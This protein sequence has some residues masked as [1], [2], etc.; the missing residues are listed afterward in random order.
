MLKS[1]I[2]RDF[3]EAVATKRGVSKAELE[4][5]SFALDGQ[6]TPAIS[7]KL[8]ITSV[9]VRKRLGEVYKKFNI[10]GSGPGKL[11]EL[12]QVLVSQYQTHQVAI[13]TSRQDWGEANNIGDFYG[14]EAELA[15]L[16][17]WVVK[18][19]CRL[20]AVLGMGGIGKTSL[21][22][23]LAER[24]QGEFENV[25]WRSLRHA[26][27]VTDLLADLIRFLSN[28]Q[29]S[30]LPPTVESISLLINYLQTSRCLLILDNAETILQSDTLTGQYRAG[31]E[32]YSELLT[33][34]GLGRVGEVPHQSCLVLTSRE[35]PQ[36]IAEY[37]GEQLLIRSLQLS[38][39]K[40][41]KEIL[42]IKGLSGSDVDT[43]KLVNRYVGNPL[44]LKI[45][46]ATIQ[47]LFD[48]NIADFLAQSTIVFGG[49]R[50]LL[51]Q[52]FNR[53]SALEEKV[54]YWLAINREE[55]VSLR[56]LQG[57]MLPPMSQRE[58]IEVLESLAKRSLIETVAGLFWLQPV[59]MEYVTARLI[60]QVCEEISG[61]HDLSVLNPESSIQ[62]LEFKTQN[63]FQS[64]ALVKAQAKDYIRNTQ[65]RC[66]LQAVT[67]RLLKNYTLGSKKGIEEN[68]K[69]ILTQLRGKSPVEIGYAGGN[70]INMLCQLQIDLTGYDFSYLTV[71]QAYLQ[72][73]DLHGVNFA[74]SNLAK[75]VFTDTFGSILSVAFSPNGQL[76]ATG[77][78]KGEVRL[79]QV[80]DSEQ[81]FTCKG[82][83]GWVKSVAF[84]PDGR[85]LASGSDDRTIKLWDTSTGQCR[86][87]LQGHGN[88]LRSVSFSPDGQ[89]L[90]SGSDDKTLRLWDASTGQALKT[91]AEYNRS[92]LSVAFSPDG[93]ILASGSSDKTLRLW[94]VNT[95]EALKPLL[96]HTRTIRSV[97]F[98][99]DGRI[100]A[101]GSSDQT[102]K[103]WDVST[104]QCLKTLSGHTS[105]VWSVAFN[106]AGQVASGS[107]DKT[108]RLWDVGTGQ[109]LKTLSGHTSR[110]WSVA[111]D[112]DDQIAS[113]SDDQ[114]VRL[115]NISTGQCIETLQGYTRSLRAVAFAPQRN[116]NSVDMRIASGGDD[117]TVRLWDGSTGQ[118]IKALQ[119]HTS[120]IWS[121]AFSPDGQT[122]ASGSDDQTVRL[123][124]VSTGQCLKILPDHTN[125]VRSVAF[126]PD[127]QTLASSSDDQT[128]KLWDVSTG[129]CLKTL[130]GHTDWVWSVA[131]RPNGETLASGSNDRT[132]RL[133]DVS[134]D[135]FQTLL[136]HTDWVRS[137]A[138]SPEGRTVA[139]SSGDRT[140]RLWDVSTGQCLKILSDMGRLRSVAFSPDGRSLAC[141][142]EDKLVT[143]WDVNTGL[144]LKTLQGHTDWVR[145]V[146]FNSQGTVLASGSKDETIKLW[147]IKTGECL[148]TLKTPRPYEGMNITG[149]T[150][151]T[152]ATVATL[153]AL[154][155]VETE[156]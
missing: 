64:H 106:S 46:S 109:C 3:L 139:S 80:T 61:S 52:Q 149:V 150:G 73:I 131:F 43:G 105:R 86:Q 145:S 4:V 41:A 7:E 156:V 60:D 14:R 119:G 124:D 110:V 153:K 53:L 88:R 89:T 8:G 34:V 27:S 47:E 135:Q 113:G 31:F 76:L 55:R 32:G 96:G 129:Q 121:V 92:L 29:E 65:V 133:W 35:K 117:R 120:R 42:R 54:M 125:W 74:H 84:S 21:S 111:F 134:T 151:L 94:N 102:L 40:E 24:I 26:P 2:P 137:V 77:D 126:S 68:L 98:S 69:Q 22:L 101:S 72:G 45:V 132:V 138:F 91:L 66:I 118:C 5:V 146:D 12:K 33:R 75:S 148:R 136:G 62:N 103:I 127:G 97:A 79:W 85:T 143:L 95:G 70:A 90:A 83:G 37:E 130:Q 57:D 140:V 48:G 63:L 23:K 154:G 112:S 16:E 128:V 11:A 30:H 93:Q 1:E 107:D 59:V 114:T 51:D 108:V 15:Q 82:H 104:G 10:Q 141:V 9:A 36:E 100:L 144:R 58:L 115:W 39:L 81:L 116:A 38:S 155:A 13:A 28:G 56:E 50:N 152:D 147:D 78:A 20:V 49:I 99:P 142:S 18:D 19:R 44:A 67:D 6:P 122:L 25:I 87:T 17:Q 123:W 71:W